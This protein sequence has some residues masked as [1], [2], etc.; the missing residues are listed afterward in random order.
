MVD[1]GQNLKLGL[2][3]IGNEVQRPP[4]QKACSNRTCRSR[5]SKMPP[6]T[7]GEQTGRTEVT[8]F[9]KEASDMVA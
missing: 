5:W 4:E 1:E 7:K 6:E 9:V 3:G 2:G 8:Y